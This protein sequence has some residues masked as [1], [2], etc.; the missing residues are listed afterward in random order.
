MLY[1][2][3]LRQV[4]RAATLALGLACCL[5]ALSPA[6]QAQDSTIVLKGDEYRLVDGRWYSHFSGAPGDPVLLNRLVIRLQNGVPLGGY[7][8]NRVGGSQDLFVEP[9]ALPGDYWVLRV[10]TSRSPISVAED[11]AGDTSVGS[12]AS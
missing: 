3:C 9:K 12:V 8:F 6:V 1:R 10:G 5:Q 2:T 4:F 11:F 7:D